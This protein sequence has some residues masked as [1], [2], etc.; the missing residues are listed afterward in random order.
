MPKKDIVINPDFYRFDDDLFLE[1]IT[2]IVKLEPDQK[3]TARELIDAER[4]DELTD[5]ER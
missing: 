1:M 5:L 4:Y 3:T 2:A